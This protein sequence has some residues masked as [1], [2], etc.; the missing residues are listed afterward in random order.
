MA[1]KNIITHEGILDLSGLEIPCYVLSDGTRVLSG[2]GMQV[3]LKMV[4]EDESSQTAGTRLAR[5]LNQKTL[6][7]FIFN[8]KPSD[9]YEPIICYQGDKKINGYEA[10]VLA[11][12]CDAF[13]E[14]RK[15]INLS[16]R[17]S[18]I[19]DQCEILM[20]GFARVGIIALVDEATGYQHEREKDEL[21]K[22]LSAYISEELLQWQKRFPDEFYKEIFRLRKWNFTVGNIKARPGVIGR[23]TNK[24]VYMNLPQGVLLE[25]KKKT[26]KNESGNYTARF[27]QSLSL[28]VGNPHLEKQLVS[29]I[30][31][32]NV[33]KDWSE[34]I[35]LYNKKFGQLELDFD[36]DE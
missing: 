23:W 24:L 11:D 25:L 32:M 18:V 27:H 7:S 14:A 33:S 8:G 4:D 30:T 29:I 28:D 1:N 16:S 10:T 20:R 34:F 3:A 31:L 19:A 17:Q 26:P 12:L 9:H 35:K 5:H 6:N 2:R 15:N 21:Q 22:I 36:E 13:L